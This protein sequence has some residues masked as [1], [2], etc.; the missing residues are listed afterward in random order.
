MASVKLYGLCIDI[1]ISCRPLGLCENLHFFFFQSAASGIHSKVVAYEPEQ[2]FLDKGKERIEKSVS[3]LVSKEKITQEAADHLL[4]TINFTTD[5]TELRNVDFTVEAVIENLDL[6]EKIYRELGSICKSETVFA[7]NTSSLSITEMAAFSGR[8]ENF[9][10][11]HFF[12][13]VQVRDTH[14]VIRNFDWNNAYVF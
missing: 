12:N 11:V 2:K 3:K 13:P 6:K 5:L 9:V 14:L 1:S 4:G 10:G 8:P 7:S